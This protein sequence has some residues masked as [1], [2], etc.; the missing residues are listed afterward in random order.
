MDSLVPWGHHQLPEHQRTDHAGDIQPGSPCLLGQQ[1]TLGV[2][3]GPIELVDGSVWFW[4]YLRCTP[5]PTVEC[6]SIRT[7]AYACLPVPRTAEVGWRHIGGTLLLN[8]NVLSLAVNTFNHDTS[9][10]LYLGDSTPKLVVFP[11]RI[12]VPGLRLA[13]PG[14]GHRARQSHLYLVRH[15]R[16]LRVAWS[17]RRQSTPRPSFPEPTTWWLAVAV[18]RRWPPWTWLGAWT[19]RFA[20]S[21]IQ[22]LPSSSQA[23]SAHVIGA[24]DGSVTWTASGGALTSTGMYTAPAIEGT[25][26]LTATS[27]AYPD[28]SASATVVVKAGGSGGGMPAPLIINTFTT[29]TPAVATGQPAKF[30]Q[31][32]GHR[33]Q[34]APARTPDVTGRT[35]GVAVR[36]TATT[37]Y[38]LAAINAV[39]STSSQAITISVSNEVVSV[40]ITPKTHS[41]TAS[42]QVQ[43]GSIYPPRP[44]ALSGVAPVGLSL[45]EGSIPRLRAAG[46][47]TVTVASVDDPARTTP[48]Q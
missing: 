37:T 18:S 42:G 12:T 35:R 4:G 28:R 29:D 11:R 1:S 10:A 13:L 9:P 15:R 23:F 36:P 25:Y 48:Q 43:F 46:T 17:P 45:P 5:A 26:T 6:G 32:D 39:G 40:S 33:A 38:T 2:G 24:S 47:F 21:F 3:T 30:P 27:V 20:P 41:L 31:L 19:S 16:G 7:A 8:G 34:Q 22:L 44:L 14:F